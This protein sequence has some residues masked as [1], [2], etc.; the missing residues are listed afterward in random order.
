MLE[1]VLAALIQTAL[2]Q[3]P[4]LPVSLDR[5]RAGLATP[6]IFDP[7]KPRPWRRLVFRATVEE[8]FLYEWKPWVEFDP[9][10]QLDFQP[11]VSPAHFQFL[12]SVTPESAGAGV[13]LGVDVL[14]ALGAA[15]RFIGKRI[16]AMKEARAKK[17][18]AEAMKAAGIR[19]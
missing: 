2:A 6:G 19:K 12:Q 10:I 9:P 15:R 17:E 13:G 11:R 8:R 18:V 16:D 14:P 1:M 3:E 5:L 7:P 4:T